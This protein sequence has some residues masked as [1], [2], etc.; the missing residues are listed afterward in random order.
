[1]FNVSIPEISK[2]ELLRRSRKIKPIID[3]TPSLGKAYTFANLSFE[4]LISKDCLIAFSEEPKAEINL[5]DLETFKDIICL[6]S[7]NERGYFQV[8]TGEILAQIS[9]CDVPVV[10]AFEVIDAPEFTGLFASD[11]GYAAHDK[12]LAIFTVRLYKNKG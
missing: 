5:A 10:T 11:L 12:G 1:M 4:E 6:A 8:I 3:S 2:A 7:C 9:D